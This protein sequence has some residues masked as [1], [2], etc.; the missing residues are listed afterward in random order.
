MIPLDRCKKILTSNGNELTD[1]EI[2]I[3]RD[4]LYSLATIALDTK[5]VNDDE[6][7]KR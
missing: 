3:I 1:Y 4:K 5:E 2:K 7:S 6:E